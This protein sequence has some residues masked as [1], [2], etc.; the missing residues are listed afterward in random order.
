VLA[1][2]EPA[3]P[4]LLWSEY[5]IQSGDNLARIFKQQELD[6][7]LLHRI[8]NS[9]PE[10]ASLAKIKPG[11]T[12]V[13]GRDAGGQ[14][15]HLTLQRDRLTRLE[16]DINE[17]GI[18]ASE[19]RLATDLRQ[20]EA[21]GTIRSS[22][23]VDGQAAGLDDGLIM[24]MAAIFGWDIDFALELREDDRFR[25]IF[26]EEWLGDAKIDNGNILAAEF[27]NQ[28]K[29]YRA[30]RHVDS[31]GTASYYDEEGRNKRRA[32]I[33]TPVKFARVSSGFTKRRWHPI[34]KTWRSHK[35]VDYAAPTG[36][37]VRATGK[38][39][40]SFIG[41][42]GGYG[43]VIFLKHG[44]KYTTVYGH[45]SRFAKGIRNGTAVRQGQVIGYVGQ[46]GLASGPHLHYEFRVHGVHRNPL[47]VKL[48]V[49]EALPQAELA[50]FRQQIQ[51][52]LA[53]LQQ[54]GGSE[55]LVV[56][57]ADE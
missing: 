21:S 6:A 15:R 24:E 42:K 35:G 51:P 12:L 28:G 7:G 18:E 33:R 5:L 56:A 38:G 10:A 53:Q 19:Q 30:F 34:L 50:E 32:F 39:S 23:F 36:T 25:V 57:Q 40:V 31:S 8:T 1:E 41:N 55:P 3:V 17:Q 9:N 27:V 47:T 48:P 22:L 13:F 44:G 4:G 52:Y 11:Q 43:K 46:T 2:P 54:G 26:E 29:I 16:I 37:P 14:L 20:R 49:S 45:L